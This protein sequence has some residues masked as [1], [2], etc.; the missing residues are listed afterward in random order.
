[1]TPAAP[2]RVAPS[3]RIALGLAVGCA[4]DAPPDDSRPS[5]D[6]TL[7]AI[8]VETL[9]DLGWGNYSL[10][11]WELGQTLDP[12]LRTK[13]GAAPRVH[14]FGPADPPPGPPRPTLLWLHGGSLDKDSE[15]N[16]TGIIGYCAD[17]HAHSDDPG[18]HQREPALGLRGDA[19]LGGRACPR[20]P[21]ATA[22]QAKAKTTP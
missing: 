8:Q 1:V 10:T 18:R 4:G 3:C 11:T 2:S 16:P 7:G 5:S 6:P 13:D 21:S 20:T 9:E 19:R 15:A 22:G 14:L 17:E 12:P